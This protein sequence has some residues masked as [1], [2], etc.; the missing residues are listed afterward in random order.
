MSTLAMY[1]MEYSHMGDEPRPGSIDVG[2][3]HVMVLGAREDAFIRLTT[4]HQSDVLIDPFENQMHDYI[5]LGA[6]LGD[7]GIALRWMAMAKHFG[8]VDLYT[9]RTFMPSL[10][11]EENKKMCGKGLVIVKGK[12]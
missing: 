10:T 11:D 5:T 2:F 8:L 3:F 12:D 9:P 7:Q 4:E 6:W 1:V